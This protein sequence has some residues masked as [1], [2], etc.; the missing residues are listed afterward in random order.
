MV[1]PVIVMTSMVMMVGM[2]R[3]REE[4]R[5]VGGGFPSV[6]LDEMRKTADI[7]IALLWFSMSIDLRS[8]PNHGPRPAGKAVDMLLLHYTGM[9]SAEAALDRLCDPAAEVSA[10]YLI[11]E[12]G[13]IWQLVAED[14]RAWHAGKAFW[15][16]E[17]DING[18]SIG[19][20]LVNPGHEFGYRPFP[21][22]QMAAL[23]GLARA[24]M[25]RHGI[26]PRRV[27]G[28]SDVAPARKADPGELFDWAF[29]A[30]AG[31]AFLPD[32][33][34]VPARIPGLGEAQAAL[35]R[36]GYEVVVTGRA[37]EATARTVQA[38][39]RHFRPR[40]CDGIL[41]AETLWRIAVVA[42]GG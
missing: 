5:L 4:S 23:A 41:D 12:D 30:R 17:R 19:I 13:R 18:V 20:E 39:Q 6:P 25:G 27:L 7:A 29:L 33:P 10:H 14:R 32:F 40:L 36:I 42:E 15:A 28:H 16:G 34:P 38:F 9:E 37:D 8:S 2:F 21:G 3:H 22:T 35:A 31:I 26:P 1:V 24:V 11:E